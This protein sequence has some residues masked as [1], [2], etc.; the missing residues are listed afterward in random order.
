[1]MKVALSNIQENNV[2]RHFWG[3]AKM[4]LTESFFSQRKEDNPNNDISY[5]E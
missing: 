3:G 1:M 4:R 5:A 2:K